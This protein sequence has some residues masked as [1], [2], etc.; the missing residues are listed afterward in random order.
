MLTN[1]YA[2]TILCSR[3]SHGYYCQYLCNALMKLWSRIQDKGSTTNAILDKQRR[4]FS[5]ISKKSKVVLNKHY[6]SPEDYY[7]IFAY[8]CW[9][10]EAFAI[11][12]NVSIGFF[13]RMLLLNKRVIAKYG[14]S[15]RRPAALR[16]RGSSCH[17][18][19]NQ[20]APPF[21]DRLLTVPA[22]RVP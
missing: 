8:F 5:L 9:H 10:T 13:C 1:I 11:Y 2:N 20:S 16:R 18:R 3:P 4:E 22:N 6:F 7:E 12:L 15:P 14:A 19:K 17:S 21:C